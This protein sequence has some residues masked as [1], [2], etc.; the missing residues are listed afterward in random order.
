MGTFDE[1]IVSYLVEKKRFVPLEK[2]ARDNQITIGKSF[3]ICLK[4]EDRIARKRL[5]ENEGSGNLF[6]YFNNRTIRQQVLSYLKEYEVVSVDDIQKEMVVSVRD[7]CSYMSGNP[8]ITRRDIYGANGRTT[9]F[10]YKKSD[11]SPLVKGTVVIGG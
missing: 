2:I 3:Y 11:V 4:N 6:G 9:I 10:T 7:I 5:G 1:R 8:S